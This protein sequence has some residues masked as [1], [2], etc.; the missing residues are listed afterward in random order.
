MQR[1][2]LGR[3][4]LSVSPIALGCWPLAGM[5]SGPVETETAVATVRTCFEN[6][7]DFLDTAYCY[8]LQGESE[9]AIGAA[10][11]AA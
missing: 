11:G 9:A 6:G 2:P 3:S 5:T 7:V 1:R 8:G 4:G 10:L